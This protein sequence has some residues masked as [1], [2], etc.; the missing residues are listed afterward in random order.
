MTVS[1]MKKML[2]NAGVTLIGGTVEENPTAYKDIRTVIAAQDELVEVIGTFQP[3]I[4]RMN[5]E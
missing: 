1:A 2:A 3:R 5:K 4:V